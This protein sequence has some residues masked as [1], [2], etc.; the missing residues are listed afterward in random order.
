MKA[1]GEAFEVALRVRL[2]QT[3]FV[4]GDCF[5]R[6]AFAFGL[7]D[8]QAG[9]LIRHVQEPLGDADID[10]QHVGHQL[11]LHAQRRQYGAAVRRRCRAFR[12]IEVGEHFGRHQRLSRRRHEGLQVGPSDRRRIAD[13]GRQGDRLDAQQP[14]RPPADLDAAFEHGRYRPAGAAQIDEQ[15]LREGRAVRPTSMAVLAPPKVAAARS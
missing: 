12:Q 4:A 3:Q 11:R 14:Q 5:K 9:N 1:V 15:L 2:D 8:Q 13:F 7:A 10:H 6:R